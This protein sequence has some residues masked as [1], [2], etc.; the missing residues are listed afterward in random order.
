MT[1]RGDITT[2]RLLLY[3]AM[4]V[5]GKL[6]IFEDQNT[7]EQ[8]RKNFKLIDKTMDGFDLTEIWINPDNPEEWDFAIE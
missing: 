4:G 6:L 5:N 7:E 1:L 8:A 3:F 2:S